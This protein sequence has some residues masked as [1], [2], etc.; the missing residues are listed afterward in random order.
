[1]VLVVM[2]LVVMVIMVTVV[3]VTVVM[4]VMVDGDLGSDFTHLLPMAMAGIAM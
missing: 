1:M 2:V 4:A 3:M